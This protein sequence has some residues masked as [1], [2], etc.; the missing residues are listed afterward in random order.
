MVTM[1]P[2]HLVSVI[3]TLNHQRVEQFQKY[4]YLMMFQMMLWFMEVTL[5]VLDPL[6]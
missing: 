4:Q 3:L 2:T 1:D 5:K 6:E